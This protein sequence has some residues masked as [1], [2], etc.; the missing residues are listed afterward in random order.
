MKKLSNKKLTPIK[1]RN[2]WKEE[3][4]KLFLPFWKTNTPARA[5]KSKTAR[6][7]L[8]KWFLQNNSNGLAK[9]NFWH[10]FDGSMHHPGENQPL[11]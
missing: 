8:L 3:M 7:N 4:P 9:S 11:V 10:M 2:R 6:L 5:I 1:Q